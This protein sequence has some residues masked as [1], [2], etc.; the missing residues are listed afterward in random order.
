[1]VASSHLMGL[2]YSMSFRRLGEVIEAWYIKVGH[3]G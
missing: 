3:D 1:M 2:T